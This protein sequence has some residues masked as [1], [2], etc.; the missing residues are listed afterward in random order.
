MHGPGSRSLVIPQVVLSILLVFLALLAMLISLALFPVRVRVYARFDGDLEY[1][2]WV[3]PPLW[4]W[5]IRGPNFMRWMTGR[6]NRGGGGTQARTSAQNANGGAPESHSGDAPAPGS[7]AGPLERVSSALSGFRRVYPSLREGIAVLAKTIRVVRLRVRAAI[8][9]GDAYETAMLCG[10]LN[11][12]FGLMLSIARRSGLRFSER[13]STRFIPV[14]EA[15][16][17]DFAADLETS[18]TIA[19]I[20]KAGLALRKTA[21]SAEPRPRTERLCS[22]KTVEY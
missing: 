19:G 7:Q 15:A 4:P 2:T 17:L 12:A 3:K 11:A 20:L 14:F 13:P 5:Y 10:G 21:A 22:Q 6:D 18:F 9:T 1:R 16:H 8:G